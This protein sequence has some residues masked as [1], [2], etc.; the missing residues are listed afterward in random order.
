[1]RPLLW[2]ASHGQRC[3][4]LLSCLTGIANVGLSLLFIYA[5]KLVIDIATGAA[6]GNLTRAGI[7][8]ALLLLAQLMTGSFDLWLNNWMQV[9][10]ANRL[11][12]Q[13]FHHLLGSRW[14]AV[15]QF[16]TGDVMNRIGQDTATIVG[17]LTVTIPAL[18]VTTVQLLA[19]FAF[20]TY[21][22]PTL[23]LI[24]IA[25]LPLCL[26]AGRFYT[27]R[28]QRYVS[29]IRKSDS[30]IQSV[31]QE[32]LQHRT[33][34]QTFEQGHRHVEQLD[35]LQT[36]L[37]AQVMSRT[38][39]S[40]LTRTA[41]AAVFSGS[42]LLAFLYGAVCLST[43]SITFGTLTAIL[44]LVNKIQRPAL[45][46][47]RLLPSFANALT[48]AERLQELE[49]LPTETSG[50][51][52]LFPHPP[53]LTLSNVTYAY[54]EGETPVI[55]HF[56]AVFPPGSHTAIMGG[57]G[58]GKTTLLRL[59]L[60]LTTPQA[61]SITLVDTK[62]RLPVGPETRCNFVYVPQ[63]NTLFSGTI[64]DNLLMG[65]PQADDVQ[66]QQ[67]LRTAVADFVLDLPQGIDTLL[68]EQGGGLSEGQAQRIA[69]ARALLRPGQILL[70]DEA[71]SA[72]DPQTEQRLQTNLRH[73]CRGKTCIFV[74]HHPA[75]AEG[76][77]RSY[78]LSTERGSTVGDR[79]PASNDAKDV[80]SSI[81]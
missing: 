25:A 81:G 80:G 15:E 10:T 52:H 72:L 32:S 35:T 71:T 43:G 47:S 69:I 18:I 26:V 5:T 33:V 3:C 22:D 1:M 59:L 55:N 37:S 79:R 50:H 42:Y 56:S 68:H 12:R 45:D 74:T 24:L 30:D 75:L 36:N 58:T 9:R 39:F 62:N 4:I 17:L 60:G 49:A 73:D 21:L 70:L 51:Q 31:I 27:R 8:A 16:H 34:L 38:R 54:R 29:K 40:L 67:A 19:T 11:R 77:E 23:P 7:F 41:L 20:F 65:N 13:L 66:L 61:G 14:N 46:L 76:C 57:T 53:E 64:R 2:R 48:A 28:M 78:R 6:P 44:Q 63:G